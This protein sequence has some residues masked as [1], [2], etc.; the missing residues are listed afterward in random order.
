MGNPAV[1]SPSQAMD[2][3]ALQDIILS[4]NKS[5]FRLNYF[6]QAVELGIVRIAIPENDRDLIEC[7][8]NSLGRGLTSPSA[9]FIISGLGFLYAKDDNEKEIH[10][11]SQRCEVT[12]C[13]MESLKKGRRN[14][15]MVSLPDW[16]EPEEKILIE[17]YIESIVLLDRAVDT[18]ENFVSVKKLYPQILE[19]LTIDRLT[20]E[21]RI[22][23]FQSCYCPF[24]RNALNPVR[25]F[26]V[27]ITTDFL[28]LEVQRTQRTLFQR[29]ARLLILRIIELWQCL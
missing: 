16:L 15:S 18:Y 19:K 29:S 2:S 28:I 26:I 6:C 4:N 24:V 23:R 17:Q 22:Q 20:L 3:L 7:C 9:E 8:L 12:R 1:L 27:P 11:Y 14:T 21:S 25:L 13:I 5:D 10:P